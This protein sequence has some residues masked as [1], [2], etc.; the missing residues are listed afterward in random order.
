VAAH[1]GQKGHDQAGK[2]AAAAAEVMVAVIS[3]NLAVNVAC[4]K[5]AI[6][7]QQQC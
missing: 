6:Q 5:L 7:Q 1:H 4:Q 3:S 2:A